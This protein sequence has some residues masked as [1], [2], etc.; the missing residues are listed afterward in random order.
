MAMINR[1]Q[2]LAEFVLRRQIKKI[3]GILHEKY[4][5]EKKEE[6]LAEQ[7]LRDIIKP[8]IKEAYQLREADLSIDI[9]DEYVIDTEEQEKEKEEIRKEEEKISDEEKAVTLGLEN[10]E[11]ITGINFAVDALKQIST[12]ISDPYNKLGDERDKQYYYDWLFINILLTLHNKEEMINPANPDEVIPAEFLEV[13]KKYQ[14]KARE[15]EENIDPSGTEPT[16]HPTGI[17]AVGRAFKVIEPQISSLYSEL[18]TDISQRKSFIKA[19]VNG[20]RNI[21]DPQRVLRVI[22]KEKAI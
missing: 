19:L 1:D 5:K 3:I 15:D 18:T 13:I 2:L 10:E 16:T 11:D 21:L 17:H 7:M 4:K 20:I 9:K 8:M 12:V 14:E 6:V 22:E